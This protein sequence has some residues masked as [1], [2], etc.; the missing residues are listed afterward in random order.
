VAA[1]NSAVLRPS[2][3]HR[4]NK[5]TPIFEFVQPRV[6]GRKSGGI[7]GDGE[8]IADDIGVFLPV[9][10]R[11]DIPKEVRVKIRERHVDIDKDYLMH[12]EPGARGNPFHLSKYLWEAALDNGA[13]EIIT[14]SVEEIDIATVT[15]AENE[16][17]RREHSCE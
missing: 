16:I 11:I 6:T 9:F 12:L 17:I 15:L 13:V 10:W 2:I 8:F 14:K 4:H 7:G 1:Y 3:P 5:R